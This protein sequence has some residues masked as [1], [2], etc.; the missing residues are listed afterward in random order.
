MLQGLAEEYKFQ[1][2]AMEVM[3]DH[4]HLLVYI[5]GQKEKEKSLTE[6]MICWRKRDADRIQLWRRIT[7]TEYPS[8][9]DTGNL[10]VCYLTEIYEQVWEELEEIPDA[11]RRFNAAEHMVHTTKKILHVLILTSASRRCHPTSE[12]LQSGMHWEVYLLTKHGWICGQSQG[13]KQGCPNWCMRIMPCLFFTVVSCTER[14][15]KEK[16]KHI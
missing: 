13:K 4:I 7:K 11:K 12:E 3:P 16:R 5:E 15:Q 10:P 1:I 14:E 8:P 6:E 9:P 2:L